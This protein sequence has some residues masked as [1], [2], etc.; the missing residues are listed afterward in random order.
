MGVLD[1]YDY[2]AIAYEYQCKLLA[3]SH[4]IQS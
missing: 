2:M 3:L 4:N 1:I